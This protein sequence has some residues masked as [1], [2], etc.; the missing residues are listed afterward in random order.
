MS[1]GIAQFVLY[2]IIIAAGFGGVFGLSNYLEKNRISLP[3]SYEDEDLSL[4]GKRL[5][6]F[7]LGGEGLMADWYWMQSL[8]YLGGK[9]V[10]TESETINLNDLRGLNP[11]LLYPYLDNATDLDPKLMAAYTYGATML[12]AIDNDQAI[13]LTQKGI[14]NNPDSW[15]LYHLL[16][17]IY[18]TNKDYDKA[19]KAYDEGI[20]IEGAPQFMKLMAASLRTQ[21]GSRET[22]RAMYGQM[23]ASNP[24]QQTKSN[25][26]FRIQELDFLDE[27]DAIDAAL[28]SFKER[29]GRCASTWNE[30]V[31]SLR[32][33]KLPAGNEFELDKSDNLVDP[34]GMPYMIDAASCR[35]QLG[36]ESTLPRPE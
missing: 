23:L 1:K 7:A 30:L 18:W 13:A 36:P 19:A 3:E 24:D 33:V 2:G 12:P 29:Q 9:L 26:E 20:K 16:G 27:R 35:V 15:N 32:N 14:A 17:Y 31:P 8:Q 28:K 34:T 5:K 10:R 21:G 6:G 4:Q 11:R 22:A 25:A